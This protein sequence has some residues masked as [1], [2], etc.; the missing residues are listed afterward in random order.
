M[1]YGNTSVETEKKATQYAKDIDGVLIHPYN[2]VEI[3]KGQG[4]I[5]LEIE[6][7]FPK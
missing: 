2:D 1:L 6:E 3:I 4:T 5:A 7:E